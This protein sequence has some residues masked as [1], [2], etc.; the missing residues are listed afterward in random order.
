MLMQTD[1]KAVAESVP[2]AKASFGSTRNYCELA[3]DAQ[4]DRQSHIRYNV[5]EPR[6]RGKQLGKPCRSGGTL[7]F[8]PC[9]DLTLLEM[10]SSLR[11]VARQ[12]LER[13]PCVLVPLG[14]LC[15]ADGYPRQA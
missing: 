12:I 14:C 8:C 3:L 2:G 7:I 4:E 1:V 10:H 6:I 9:V 5:L 11:V 13:S 15:A